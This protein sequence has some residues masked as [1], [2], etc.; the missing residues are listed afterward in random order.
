MK[1]PSIDRAV[2]VRA[3]GV[4][5]FINEI[6]PWMPPGAQAIYG[7]T[8]IAQALMAAEKTIE[9]NMVPQGIQCTFLLG[10]K[11]ESS[12]EY[13]VSRLSDSPTN[14]IRDVEVH[15]DGR[16]LL[17]ASVRYGAFAQA[18]FPNLTTTASSPT[19]P[20]DCHK[21]W[22]GGL[23]ESCPFVCSEVVIISGGHSETATVARQCMKAC[24]I[25]PTSS[26][27][28][29]H[30]AA[31][32]YMSDNYLLPTASR[33]LNI[34]WQRDPEYQKDGKLAAI[35]KDAGE[36]IGLMLTLN[37]QIRF[38]SVQDFR[39]DRLMLCEMKILWV[40]EGRALVGMEVFDIHDRLIASV[41]QEV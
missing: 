2:E 28:I 5:I 31:L 11:A 14:T 1:P 25:L 10:G 38:H 27:Q 35:S 34:Y 41:Q 20:F 18:T 6:S 13:H 17:I 3:A 12:L 22:Y 33:L 36:S 37:H 39:A 9:L 40:G 26:R 30:L 16:C 4:D 32:A 21:F 7:G 29:H 23:S 8:F 15:Q 24:E 19:W